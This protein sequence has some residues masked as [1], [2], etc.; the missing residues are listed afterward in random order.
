MQ[1]IHAPFHQALKDGRG[2][3]YTVKET[4]RA[5]SEG[6]LGLAYSRSGTCQY[7]D[8][9]YNFEKYLDPV[10]ES[11]V[12]SMRIFDSISIQMTKVD[13][14][15]QRDIVLSILN[16]I[17]W[18][19]TRWS[20]IAPHLSISWICCFTLSNIPG[21]ML[22]YELNLKAQFFVQQNL[23]NQDQLNRINW[24][25]SNGLRNKKLREVYQN[26]KFQTEVKYTTLQEFSP[27]CEI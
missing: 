22:R 23:N 9:R 26:I 20:L 15:A 21:G 27:D 14:K 7:P 1:L 10:R 19:R 24:Y 13:T 8:R 18:D 17:R 5:K 12:S 16:D 6:I 3:P 4:T 25:V 11:I 2:H